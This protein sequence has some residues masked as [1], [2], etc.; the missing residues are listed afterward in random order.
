M[1]DKYTYNAATNIYTSLL[2]DPLASGE[3]AKW[4]RKMSDLRNASATPM[5]MDVLI[6][7]GT[8]RNFDNIETG[9][10]YNIFGLP[11]SSNHFTRQNFV[12]TTHK[13]PLGIN[14]GYIDGHVKWRDFRE[15]KLQLRPEMTAPGGGMTAPIGMYFWW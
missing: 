2:P 9:D 12:G 13:I 3:K 15:T 7:D 6:D 4:I 10:S 5:V 11:D 1:F 8:G 14:T